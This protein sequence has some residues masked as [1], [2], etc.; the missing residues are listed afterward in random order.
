MRSV[1]IVDPRPFEKIIVFVDGGY[2]RGLCKTYCGH[3]NIQ[4]KSLR[5]GIVNAFNNMVEQQYPFIA[6]LIRIYFYDAI[7]K[8]GHVDFKKQRE[9][10]DKLQCQFLTLRLGELVESSNKPFKQK[11]VDILMAIDSL[12]K[13]Q[14]NQYD[15][16]VF[17]LGD[18]DFKPLIEAIKD[19][20]KK[21]LW[22]GHEKNSSPELLGSFDMG[23]SMSEESIRDMVRE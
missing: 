22:I 16:A 10:F 15:V 17:L 1:R 13:A 5:D 20:G 23:L 3:D 8:E 9:Y 14:Q 7:V 21:T 4:V 19:T 2:L 12:T 6:N 11:G 18:R